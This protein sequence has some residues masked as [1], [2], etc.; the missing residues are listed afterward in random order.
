M[1]WHR[2]AA[3]FTLCSTFLVVTASETSAAGSR[4]TVLSRFNGANGKFS[5]APLMRAA[6]GNFYGTAE[7]GGAFDKGTIFRM[8]PAGVYTVLHSFSGNPDGNAPKAG[9]IQASDGNFYGT[10]YFG[11]GLTY[12]CVF[13]MTPDGTV[14]VIHA[15][16]STPTDGQNPRA[17][18]IQA[19]D[20][21]LWGTTQKGGNADRG[22]VFA[23]N[24]QG[25]TLFQYSFTGVATV[26]IPT[27]RSLKRRTGLCT[28]RCTPAIS[29]PTA[30]PSSPG[31]GP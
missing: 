9:L 7:D 28:A 20:G 2:V 3:G 14:T 24:L 25:T 21:N 15:F 29:R 17:S 30:G 1:N 19:R 11:G 16:G 22:T 23:M 5:S 13:R 31:A 18:L 10:T 4:L 26:P 12:G 6:D 8:T 27:R